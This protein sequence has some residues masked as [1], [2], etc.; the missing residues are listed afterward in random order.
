MAV[1]ADERWQRL[2]D[3]VAY[4]REDIVKNVRAVAGDKYGRLAEYS[5]G[6]QVVYTD[7][8]HVRAY[9]AR[10]SET[11]E[12]GMT[13]FYNEES[14]NITALGMRTDHSRLDVTKDGNIRIEP[15]R[16]NEFCGFMLFT[17]ESLER[18]ST[19][20]NYGEEYGPL[21]CLLHEFGHFVA[22]FLP[23]VRSTV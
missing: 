17:R 5:R 14:D 20:S 1:Q 12:G 16:F 7:M 9:M 8:A 19:V 15:K 6:L 22:W 11:L 10:M 23:N 2:K 21:R 3:S 18:F 4:H 13:Q